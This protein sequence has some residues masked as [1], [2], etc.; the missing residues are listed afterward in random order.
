MIRDLEVLDAWRHGR[1]S[2]D[3]FTELQDR[4]RTE[5]EL[6]A[7]LRELAEVEE[8]LSALDMARANPPPPK[9]SPK[10]VSFWSHWLP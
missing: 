9:P 4:F 2:Q 6:R 5:A 8:G 3:E 10:A 7:A 1:L